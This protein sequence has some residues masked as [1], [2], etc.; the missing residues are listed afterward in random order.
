MVDWYVLLTYIALWSSFG[1]IHS[2]FAS[3]TIK[4]IF[5]LS[6]QPYRIVYNVLQGALF[7]LLLYF[8]PSITSILLG[9]R[10]LSILK[11]ILF[12]LAAGLGSLIAA[13]GFANWNLKGLIGLTKEDDPLITKG[14][15]AF[16]RHPVYTGVIL[17][18]L[19]TLIIE[20]SANSLSWVIGGGG[21]F[22]WGS[23]FEENKLKTG[24]IEY[25]EYAKNVGQFFPW[26]KI[27]VEYLLRN[28]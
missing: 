14:I 5:P 3:S 2:I 17:I 8:L 28:K 22:V 6:N 25:A 16:S 18:F 20:W 26:R 13:I 27:H 15:Y 23:Y 12:L 7:L 10:D 11:I 1:I 19:S 4:R 21:Y 9:I 24:F